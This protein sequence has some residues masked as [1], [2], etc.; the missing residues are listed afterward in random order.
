MLMM[1]AVVADCCMSRISAEKRTAGMTVPSRRRCG[2]VDA[3]FGRIGMEKHRIVH[4]HQN[5]LLDGCGTRC[6]AGVLHPMRST[7]AMC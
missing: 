4:N 5:T 6:R 3:R 1:V 7:H 2:Q